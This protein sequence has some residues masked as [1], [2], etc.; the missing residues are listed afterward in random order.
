M[1][2]KTTEYKGTEEVHSEYTFDVASK[3][4]NNNLYN[5]EA[6]A[7]SVSLYNTPYAPSTKVAMKPV[8]SLGEKVTATMDFTITKGKDETDEVRAWRVDDNDNPDENGAN[9]HIDT[10]GATAGTYKVSVLI[11][12]E[13]GNNTKEITKNINVRVTDALSSVMKDGKWTVSGDTIL[14]D[15]L[16]AISAT[17]K[18]EVKDLKIT[19]YQ[20]MDDST[21][22]KLAVYV[23]GKPVGYMRT[24]GVDK[25]SDGWAIGQTV[26][27]KT[28]DT[29]DAI[30]FSAVNAYVYS[31][32]NYYNDVVG[33]TLYLGN[34][35]TDKNAMNY[36][37]KDK[38]VSTNTI[39][40]GGSVKIYSESGNTVSEVY[41]YGDGN[42]KNNVAKAGSY[43]VVVKYGANFADGKQLGNAGKFNV[44]YSLTMPTVEYNLSEQAEVKV[45]S[46]VDLVRAED[47]YSVSYSSNNG[48][49]EAGV[50]K[51]NSGIIGGYVFGTAGLS[52][53]SKIYA[54]CV[55]D[56]RGG[57]SW[58][59]N[60]NGASGW[61]MGRPGD[62][63][64]LGKYAFNG[65]EY[66]G[67]VLIHFVIEKTSKITA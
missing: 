19:D 27:K 59:A 29:T 18:V 49:K 28:M 5:V 3:E 30:D 55:D 52:K 38:A 10:L 11:S 62:A 25:Y 20:G 57:W 54:V 33:T 2:V 48:T 40:V 8:N 23:G 64:A 41:Y 22:V 32:S 67:G 24:W 35:G 36:T 46:N 26:L 53:G 1:T 42:N 6:G 15:S 44:S 16:D 7:S 14:G 13:S 47:G 39:K 56:V 9:V 31:G 63:T 12:G 51:Y 34:N 50:L 45:K 43:N 4:F 66:Q 21:D 37:T 17:Y 58:N 60:E 65:G 61:S